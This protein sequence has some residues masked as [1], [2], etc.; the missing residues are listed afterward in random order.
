[1]LKKN[2]VALMTLALMMALAVP[3]QA[4]QGKTKRGDA[5]GGGLFPGCPLNLNLTAEQKTKLQEQHNA[6]FKDTT[7]LRSDIFK[8]D[9]ELEAMMLD[10]AVDAE[11][12]KKLQNEISDLKGQMAQKS[13]QAQLNA[14]AILSPDQIKQLPP[15]CNFGFGPGRGCGMSAGMGCGMGKGMGRGMGRGQGAF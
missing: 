15:G 7:G 8:K 12:A 11:K 2:T 1:M 6:F 9:Q 5:D 13:L 10:P 4:Q 3:A 14:R